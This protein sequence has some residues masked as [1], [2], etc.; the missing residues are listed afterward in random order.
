MSKLKGEYI[1]T[2][3]DIK[4]LEE[5]IVSCEKNWFPKTW[6]APVEDWDKFNEAKGKYNL[7]HHG[8]YHL[9]DPRMFYSSIFFPF[10]MITDNGDKIID[11]KIFK[12]EKEFQDFVKNSR[13]LIS[14]CFVGS[15]SANSKRE[16]FAVYYHKDFG[17][18]GWLQNKLQFFINKHNISKSF[19]YWFYG[20]KNSKR[21]KFR[22]NITCGD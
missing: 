2:P 4:D 11:C 16:G 10:I 6:S 19:I 14:R 9:H 13:Y 1:P 22:I 20:I 3:E 21:P 18:V 15:N 8:M 5:W 7:N 17:K 12:Y